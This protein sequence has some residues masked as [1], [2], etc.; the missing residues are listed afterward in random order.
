MFSRIGQALGRLKRVIHSTVRER[1]KIRS[2]EWRRVRK[3][4]LDANPE[5]AA[6][7]QQKRLQVHHMEP[8]H[9]EPAR[10]LDPSN[11]VTLC[12]GALECHIRIGHGDDFKAYNPLVLRHAKNAQAFPKHR[13][14]VEIEAKS[15]RLYETT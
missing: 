2:P 5:C 10:E 7:G 11:L 6:C 1:L 12:M 9:L 13:V 3:E 8:Y 4:H 14:T 15:A